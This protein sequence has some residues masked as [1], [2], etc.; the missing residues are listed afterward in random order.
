MKN[1][2]KLI[3]IIAIT[4]VIGFSFAACDNGSTNNGGGGGGGTPT[5]NTSLNG[6]WTDGTATVNI[7]GNTGVI[8]Q[9]GT[10]DALWQDAV[11]KGYIKVGDLH[12][13]NLSKTG[14][15]TWTGQRLAVSNYISVPNVAIGATTINCTITM[16]A[17][18]QTFTESDN[19]VGVFDTWTRQ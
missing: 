4:A 11:N 16:S 10:L 5:P 3:G 9:L 12:F 14:D 18:G 2:I 13:S 8:T 17:N 6:V 19:S 1:I 15:R 7:N